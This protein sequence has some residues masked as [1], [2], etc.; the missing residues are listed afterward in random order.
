MTRWRNPL[1]AAIAA[2]L[3]I[4]GALIPWLTLYAGLQ[5]LP[6]TTGLHGRLVLGAGVVLAFTAV[7]A[8][9]RPDD[10]WRWLTGL[11]GA[12]AIY[13]AARGV[14][15]LRTVAQLDELLVAAPGP[16]PWLALAGG[17]VAFGAL[18]AARP[19]RTNSNGPRPPTHAPTAA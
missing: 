16:G 17:S 9:I 8:A 6:G 19:S 2:T 4:V 3:L 13:P 11:V 15:G 14:L 18:F 10:R 1:Q 5:R 7:A 12:A